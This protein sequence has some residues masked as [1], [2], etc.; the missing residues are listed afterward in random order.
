VFAS[1]IAVYGSGQ[2]P[3]REDM[4]PKPEDP[5]GIAKY[6]VELDL[7]AARA[8]FG[9]EHVIFRPHNVYGEFQNI[10]D[11]YRNVIGIFMNQIL[12]GV[13][14]TVFGDG[15][16]QR[17]FTY[18][19]DI[20]GPIA[21]AAWTSAA[22]GRVFNVGADVA[23]SVNDLAAYVAD[24]MDAPGHPVTRLPERHE[25][26]VAFSDHGAAANVFGAGSHTTLREGL[27]RM[28]SWARRAGARPTKPFAAIEIERGLPAAWRAEA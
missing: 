24:A 19:G 13:P 2:V 26:R 8:T 16:Q 15:T 27:S 4:T 11:R 28:A 9:L 10:G 1:S 6:A 25:V 5:Y 22:Y 18:V 20:V 7:A 12:Q 14:M 17:A 3:M 21:R 23:C